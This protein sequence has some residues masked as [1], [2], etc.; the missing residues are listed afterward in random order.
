M[1]FNS[2]SEDIKASVIYN[3]SAHEIWSDLKE[4]AIH[5]CKQDTMTI[6]TYYTKL[7]SFWD[8]RH[9]LCNIPTFTC[10]TVKEVLQFQQSQKTM[11]FLMGLNESYAAVQG[12]ILLMDP[13]PTVNKTHSTGGR[14]DQPEHKTFPFKA[15]DVN[16]NS[17]APTTPFTLTTEQYRNLMTMLH[18]NKS[19]SMD[20]HV[21]SAS[22]MSDLS[23]T[24]SCAFVFGKEM[25]WL[26]T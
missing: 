25:Y 12:Q 15:N 4:Q 19:N 3:E 9:T 1:V 24:T 13:L 21:G 14:S 11:K 6:G 22:A 16:A 20:N 17:T 26:L 5:D 10:G 7:K 18:G 8:E 2:I 23:G